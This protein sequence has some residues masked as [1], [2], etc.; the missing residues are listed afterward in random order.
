MVNSP[1]I[2]SLSLTLSANVACIPETHVPAWKMLVVREAT[3]LH[4][5]E[6]GCLWNVQER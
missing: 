3:Y 6:G 5:F 2:L 4:L 1:D